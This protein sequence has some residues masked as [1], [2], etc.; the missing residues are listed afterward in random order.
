[1]SAESTVGVFTCLV[2]FVGL[3]TCG[4][5]S[6]FLWVGVSG[7][8]WLFI[9]VGFRKIIKSALA[10]TYPVHRSGAIVISG[11]SSGIGKHAALTLDSRGF[12]VYAGVRKEEDKESLLK[13]RPTLRPILL[14]V[15]ESKSVSE[16]CAKISKDLEAESLSLVG[17]VNNAGVS[18]GLPVEYSPIEEVKATFDVN[19]FGIYRLTQTFLPLLRQTK[20]R[21][22][23]ISSPSG[24]IGRPLKSVYTA[25]KAGV[26]GMSQ[27]L[28]IELYP[29][30]IA[31]ICIVPGYIQSKFASKQ[32]GDKLPFKTLDDNQKKL[33]QHVFASFLSV[34]A[35]SHS[36]GASP[37]VTSEAIYKALTE[38]KP[39]LIYPVA[40]VGR[41]S[42]AS[43]LWLLWALPLEATDTWLRKRY[44]VTASSK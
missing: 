40:G 16:A 38:P 34:F 17:I 22:I 29:F 10:C 26:E 8:C 21:I 43:L 32:T 15:T 28:R 19:L 18:P 2:G 31:V 9:C 42:V 11:C 1:M 27:S 25:T 24:R 5:L 6:S 14:D 39:E 20:G 3:C 33:Y 12:T 13:Q 44:V 7:V 23:M 4:N 37:Q 41:M 35:K 30:K 36:L